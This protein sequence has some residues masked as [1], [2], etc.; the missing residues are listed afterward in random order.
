MTEIT[1]KLS[2]EM[3]AFLR[4]K[5]ASGAYS[6]SSEVIEDGLRALTK[7]DEAF[8]NWLRHEVVPAYDQM[9]RDPSRGLS[10]D[11]VRDDLARRRVQRKA[12]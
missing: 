7:Q 3:A 10:V 8:E 6:T 1:I 4:E 5:V 2:E 11:E 9:Q 12:R